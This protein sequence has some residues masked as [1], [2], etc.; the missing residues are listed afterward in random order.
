MELA[1]SGYAD[2]RKNAKEV[3]SMSMTKEAVKDRMKDG[4]VVVLN[5]LPENDYAKLH[6]K[7]SESLPM[8]LNSNDFVQAVEKKYGKTNFFITYCAGPNCNVG[9]N[10]A[11]ALQDQGFKANDYA[12]GILEWSNAGYPVEG[13]EVK[14][15][16]GI[17]EAARVAA[18]LPGSR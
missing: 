18:T 15:P 6:I 10:A 12:G 8:G 9:P 16:G 7:G 11:K 17:G 5:V 4:N 13:S 2:G 14:D 1:L 3:K